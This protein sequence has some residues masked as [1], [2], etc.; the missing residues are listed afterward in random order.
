MD[1]VLSRDLSN[2]Q[3]LSPEQLEG[4][5]ELVI[6]FLID[7]KG[8]GF[9][10]KLGVYAET[11]GMG[12]AALKTIVRASLLFLQRGVRAGWV[13][14]QVTEA[15]AGMGL[16]PEVAEVISRCWAQ[17]SSNLTSSLLS[18]IVS[19]NQLMDVD[20][21]FGVTA[22]TDDSDQVCTVCTLLASHSQTLRVFV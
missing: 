16:S 5:M 11:H 3:S 18:K 8:S 1:E 7:A 17:Q 4:L 12:G 10:E 20:W 15:C 21:S 19:A 6:S 2:L 9:Q 14:E 13:T 22:A